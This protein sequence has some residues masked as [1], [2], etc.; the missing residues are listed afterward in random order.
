MSSPHAAAAA[1]LRAAAAWLRA[2]AVWLG[3]VRV[4]VMACLLFAIGQRTANPV[5]TVMQL[6]S[7]VVLAG[8]LEAVYR[9]LRIRAVCAVYGG[10]SRVLHRDRRP[11][12]PRLSPPPHGGGRAE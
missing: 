6:I 9:A 10:P 11:G 3:A 1:C 7:S 8:Q 2:A 4:A 5:W 12:E